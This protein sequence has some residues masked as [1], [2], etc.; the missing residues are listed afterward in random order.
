M[1]SFV[2]LIAVIL[3]LLFLDNVKF[4]FISSIGLA[5]I[6][7]LLFSN[8][9]YFVSLFYFLFLEF[10]FLVLV[11][12]FLPKGIK[13]CFCFLPRESNIDCFSYLGNQTLI[14]FQRHLSSFISDSFF[15]FTST[16]NIFSV[17]QRFLLFIFYNFSLCLLYIIYSFLHLFPRY[18]FWLC[19]IV[20]LFPFFLLALNLFHLYVSFPSLSTYFQD[21]LSC[22]DNK[23]IHLSSLLYGEQTNSSIFSLVWTTN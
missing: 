4:L 1:S 3:S 8:P 19:L 21:L 11:V 13:H 16:S 7:F 5:N 2:L 14:V 17:K 10:C 23:L 18:H 6:I 22:M 9:F 12:R 20:V 15:L